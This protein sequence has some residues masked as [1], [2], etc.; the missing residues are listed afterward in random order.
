MAVT[1]PVIISYY[2][3]PPRYFYLR[4]KVDILAFLGGRLDI[5]RKIK[6]M[7]PPHCHAC[8]CLCLAVA[9]A[10]SAVVG[11][12]SAVAVEIIVAVAVAASVQVLMASLAY[13]S[14]KGFQ[15][16]VT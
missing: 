3:K 16:I 4:G 14:L 15:P 1:P 5:C 10:V 11:A 7:L 8:P 6:A 2:F 13:K 9:A 12:V